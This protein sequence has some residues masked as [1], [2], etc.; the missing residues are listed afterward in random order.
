ML[1]LKKSTCVITAILL[2]LFVLSASAS[3]VTVDGVLENIEW[4]GSEPFIV[5]K[6]GVPTNC[7]INFA[8]MKVKTD[9]NEQAVYLGFQATQDN[10]HALV[11]DNALAGVRINLKDNEYVVCTQSGISDYD[12]NAYNMISKII[13]GSNNDFTVEVRIGFKYGIPEKALQGIQIVDGDGSP[14]NYYNWSVVQT[15]EATT[16]EKAT[17]TKETTTKAPTT[18]KETTTKETTTKAP[19]AIKETTTKA[20]TTKKETTAKEPTTISTT[21]KATTAKVTTINATTAKATSSKT[22]IIKETTTQK[23]AVTTKYFQNTTKSTYPASI[24]SE[25]MQTSAAIL[26][27][28]VQ[29]AQLQTSQTEPSGTTYSNDATDVAA[30][31]TGISKS[32]QIAAIAVA[33]L[34]IAIAVC[35]CVYA[36][37]PKKTVKPSGI[38]EQENEDVNF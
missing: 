7:L 31:S 38:E 29:P 37:A 33:V 20:P 10:T 13:I 24:Y 6:S 16:T 15:T 25:E 5:F 23:S 9:S 36:G 18:K 35:L 8:M 11:A 22:T 27:S 3:A 32:K 14:S 21:V 28:A 2:A 17:T 12:V 34:L 19:T 4:Q 1:T 26:T 30:N